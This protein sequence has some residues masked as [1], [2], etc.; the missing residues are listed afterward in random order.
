MYQ[1]LCEVSIHVFIFYS[2]IYVKFNII[3]NYNFT[4]FL[5]THSF[6][7]TL[8][9]TQNNS[10]IWTL[11]LS[12]LHSIF[13]LSCIWWVNFDFHIINYFRLIFQNFIHK[14]INNFLYFKYIFTF[15]IY[16]L[17]MKLLLREVAWF[18]SNLLLLDF[19]F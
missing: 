17:R 18:N 15:L 7:L 6:S 1:S 14:K 2:I 11:L 8:L 13:S 12:S 9:F 3:N 16:I 19:T 10:E 4:S 5:I